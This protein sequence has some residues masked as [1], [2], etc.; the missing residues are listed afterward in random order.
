MRI[1]AFGLSRFWKG[2]QVLIFATVSGPCLKSTGIPAQNAPKCPYLL[3]SY[4]ISYFSAIRRNGIRI[5]FNN[6]LLERIL[7]E[8]RLCPSLQR[9]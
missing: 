9:R 4:Q 7:H 1:R 3:K 6:S 2:I 8:C 5:Q